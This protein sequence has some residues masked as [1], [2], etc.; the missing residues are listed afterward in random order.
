[1]KHCVE[2]DNHQE[3]DLKDVLWT[4]ELD[5]E[6]VPGSFTVD[7]IPNIPCLDEGQISWNISLWKSGRSI[8]LCFETRS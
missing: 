7:G 6:F 4:Q 1:M 5:G 3:F 8:R 2:V